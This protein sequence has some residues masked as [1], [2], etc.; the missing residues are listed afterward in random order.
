MARPIK[1][2][3]MDVPVYRIGRPAGDLDAGQASAPTEAK[4]GAAIDN[5]PLRWFR[6]EIVPEYLKKGEKPRIDD[7]QPLALRRFPSLTPRSFY[8]KVWTPGA[9]KAWLKGGRPK[10]PTRTEKAKRR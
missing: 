8:L 7:V 9:P 5:E 10:G 1:T 6:D 2:F 4:A 3:T